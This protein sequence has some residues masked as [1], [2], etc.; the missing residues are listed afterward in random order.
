MPTL[1]IVTGK[2]A[3]QRVDV[4]S[5]ES[6]VTFGNRRTATVVLKDPWISFMHAVIMRKDGAYVVADKRS[7]AGTFLNG[8]KVDE[9]GRPLKDGDTIGLGKTEIRF[10]DAGGGG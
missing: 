5:A 8:Q 9:R 3:G 4:S 7:R 6:E 1:E 2:S 10:R